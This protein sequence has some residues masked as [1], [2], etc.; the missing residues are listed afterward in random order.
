MSTA[1]MTLTK[2]LSVAIKN[3]NSLS[4]E[5]QKW[6]AFFISLNERLGKSGMSFL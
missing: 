4:H 3:L 2:I 5:T 1:A 6:V